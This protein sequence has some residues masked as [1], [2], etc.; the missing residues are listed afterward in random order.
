[1]QSKLVIGFI[2]SGNMA[3]A[4]IQG[5]VDN[6]Y[7]KN[8]IKISDIDKSLL[9]KRKQQFGVDTYNE[10]KDICSNCDV[11]I[12]A[13]KPQILNTICTEIK[14]HIKKD[15]LII[16][17]A[18]GVSVDSIYRWLD[19]KHA[20]IRAMPNTPILV[21]QG[22]TGLF[23]NNLV[24]TEQKELIASLLSNISYCF[25]VE[26]EET[27]DAVTAISGSGPAYFLLMMQAITKAATSI[28]IEENIAKEIT[29]RTILGTSIMADNSNKDLQQ[30]RFDITS[31][32]GTTEAAIDY[33]QNKNFENIIN[34]AIKIAFN[35]AKELK[36]E[37]D[38]AT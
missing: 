12:L 35:R 18:A 17:I 21:K 32:K 22:V 2:G 36:S 26:K 8:N 19:K 38:N 34:T 1:M 6:N 7:N 30:L 9:E 4:I 15:N 25:W 27:I 33:L 5:L 23:A 28:G 3:N 10:N 20:L 24:S 31:K 16:S 11:V 14:H 13:V 29:T 37:M